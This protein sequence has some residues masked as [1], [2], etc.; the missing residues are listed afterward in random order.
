M[1]FAVYNVENLFQRAR[2]L[3]LE[4]WVEGKEILKDHAALNAVLNKPRYSPADKRRIIELMQ[5]LGIAE[6]DDG[7]RFVVLHRNRGKLVKRPRAGGLEVVAEGR[8]DWVGWLDLKFE[9]VDEVATLNTARVIRDVNADVLGVV[10]SETRP[11][12]VRFSDQ[13]LP[14]VDGKPYERIMLIDGNDERGIDIG[15]LL[16]APSS[17]P[18][19]A[20]TS[21]TTTT[22][23]ASSAAI[24]PNTSSAS[25]RATRSRCS[26]T[27]QEQGLRQLRGEQPAPRAAGRARAR[28]LRGAGRLRHRQRGRDG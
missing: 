11:A 25:R 27:T 19:C 26:S 23:A 18:G 13:V 16:R 7:G 3:N 8:S 9:E 14:A 15:I 17:C 21:T 1:R 4:T 12:L 28:A 10:E 22:R 6:R 24:A 5:E 20:A 2:A